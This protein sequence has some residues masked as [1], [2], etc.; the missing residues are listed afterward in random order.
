[1]T[2]RADLQE[3][4]SIPQTC[5]DDFIILFGNALIQIHPFRFSW[6]EY[7]TFASNFEIISSNTLLSHVVELLNLGEGK[8]KRREKDTEGNRERKGIRY[9]STIVEFNMDSKTE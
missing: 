2:G 8:E 7:C 1:M 4:S 6:N 9:D 3:T 5:G